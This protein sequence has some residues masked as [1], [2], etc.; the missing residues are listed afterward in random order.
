MYRVFCA[1]LFLSAGSNSG[2]FVK[3]LFAELQAQ[4]LPG[5]P[6]QASGLVLT[7]PRVIQEPRRQEPIDL[8]VGLRVEVAGVGPQPP[9]EKRLQ[10]WSF[11]RRHRR[12][13]FAGASQ[14][15]GQEGREQDAAAGAK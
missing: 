15:F 9:A 14:E 3:P 2:I 6:Q 5:D 11:P 1:S 12:G 4:G 7:A 13:R 10:A 8:A